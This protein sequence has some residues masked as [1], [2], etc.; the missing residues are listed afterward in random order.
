MVKRRAV[1]E[2]ML[3]QGVDKGLLRADLDA[4]A[5]FDLIAG[6]FYY[7]LVV[8]GDSIDEPVVRVRCRLALDIAWRGMTSDVS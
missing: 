8:R 4:F 7:Q 1:L 2:D 5:A 3:R 6:V